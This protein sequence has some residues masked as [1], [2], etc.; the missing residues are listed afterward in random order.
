M[1]TISTVTIRGAGMAGL[2]YGGA[3]TELSAAGIRPTSYMGTSAGAIAAAVWATTGAEALEQVMRDVEFARFARDLDPRAGRTLELAFDAWRLWRR[4]GL[5]SG[6][7]LRA[8]LF[9]LFGSMTFEELSMEHERALMVWAYDIRARRPA[10]FGP[11]RTP[12]VS[13]A[14][15]VHASCA[16]PGY[17]VPVEIAGCHYVD[18]GVA[19]N[20]PLGSLARCS[21]PGNV[22]GLRMINSGAPQRVQS[23]PHYSPRVSGRE[24]LTCLGRSLTGAAESVAWDVM[25][26][27]WRA[28]SIAIPRLGVGAT[29]WRIDRETIDAL[30]ESGR[31]SARKWL[32]EA[33]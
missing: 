3:A 11:D 22:V 4:G 31:S 18:G 10:L 25:G 17:F 23:V 15:A 16:I 21:T 26:P 5:N 9:D 1:H 33:Q 12:S 30:L 13:I 28:R 27:E 32:E 24:L 8:W 19:W 29:D 20:D 7:R 2:A 14:E 6:A